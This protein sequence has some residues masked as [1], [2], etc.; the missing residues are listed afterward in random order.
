VNGRDL[1]EALP[2]DRLNGL[3]ANIRRRT[4]QSVVPQIRAQVETMVDHAEGL[5]Q[6]RLPPLL[7]QAR[8]RV[9]ALM[10]PEIRR[11]EAL[12]KRNPM[13]RDSE[14]AYFRQQLQSARQAIDKAQLVPEGIR[15]I[16]TS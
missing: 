11:L 7:A 2:H 3:C 10:Q 12:S 15:V 4:A 13:V 9:D 5:A 16:V 1:G 8:E 6:Q 14:I